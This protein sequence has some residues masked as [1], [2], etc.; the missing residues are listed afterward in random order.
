MSQDSLVAR[1]QYLFLNIAALILYF[2][3][4]YSFGFPKS[5]DTTIYFSGDA[6]EY[7]DY[8]EWLKGNSSYCSAVRPFFFPLLLLI[9]NYIAGTYGIWFMLFSFWMI[10]INLLFYSLFRLTQSLILSFIG[11]FIFMSNLSLIVLTLHALPETTVILFLSLFTF[12]VTR[13]YHKRKSG[14]F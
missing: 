3:V 14:E 8:T 6:R 5:L 13:Y 9:S 7:R 10:S 12:Y 4:V 11:I 2:I 1:R